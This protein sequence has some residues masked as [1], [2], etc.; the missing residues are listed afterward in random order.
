MSTNLKKSLLIGVAVFLVIALSVLTVYLV[1][2]P[3]PP[4]PSPT[5][6]PVAS[7]IESPV[8]A[9]IFVVDPLAAC[10]STFTVACGSSAPSATPS[11][12]PSAT[13]SAQVYPST[14]PSTPPSSALDCV[15]KR[16]Y[17]DDSR[18]RAGFYYTENEIID[19]NTLENGQVI[20][21]NVVIKNGGGNSASGTTIT[22]TLS[23]NL[24]Y[25]DGDSGCTYEPS[26]RMVSCV[27]GELAASTE[28]ARSFRTR[29]SV[30]GS[31]AVA[32]TAEVSSTNGQRDSCSI[33]IDATGKVVTSVPSP[34]P[35]S[36]PVAGVFE[37]TTS[38][39]GVGVLLLIA[40]VLG[41]LLI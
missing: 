2:K 37:V 14:S 33:E 17:A 41:L 10:T 20:L 31:T 24:A 9:P 30:A 4:A 18:N 16:I 28:A 8:A 34:V 25:I 7:P 40:G 26:T 32:N 36:L 12:I 5:P 29:V 39:L 21:Y 11:A 23:T 38:T 3:A 1:R 15:V 6:K 19:T 35:T 27:I 22:D 13:P